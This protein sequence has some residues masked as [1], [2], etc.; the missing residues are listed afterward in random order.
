MKLSQLKSLLQ[1]NRDKQFLLQLPNQKDVPHS[2]HITEVGLV[3]KKFIDCGGKIHSTQTCQ[4]QAWIGSDTDHRIEAGKMADILQISASIL[5]HDELEV[6]IEYE[7]EMIS[8]YP[9]ANALVDETSVVLQLTPKHT[10][11]LAKELCG[12]PSSDDA[13]C[14]GPSCC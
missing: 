1:T 6:E 9:I 3:D 8:Q 11:C 10:D 5:P 13:A 2:F 4:L 14:C 7:D 12:V